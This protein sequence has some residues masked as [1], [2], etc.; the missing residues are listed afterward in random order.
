[1]DYAVSTTSCYQWLGVANIQSF[2]GAT[3]YPPMIFHT[4][5][6]SCPKLPYYQMTILCSDTQNLHLN[7]KYMGPMHVI[8]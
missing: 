8:T 6:L 7:T 1:M 2:N 4:S 5:R 3:V